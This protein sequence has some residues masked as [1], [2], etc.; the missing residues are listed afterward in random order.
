MHFEGAQSL[1]VVQ[2]QDPF[3]HGDKHVGNEV[4]HAH[5]GTK[6]FANH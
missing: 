1:V 4:Y 2:I 3:H 5:M 6:V